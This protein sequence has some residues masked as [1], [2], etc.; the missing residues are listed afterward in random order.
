VYAIAVWALPFAHAV[1]LDGVPG[2]AAHAESQGTHDHR[3]AH[4]SLDCTIF[5]VARLL[6]APPQRVAIPAAGPVVAAARSSA[7]DGPRL[8]L[9]RGPHRSRAPP[10]A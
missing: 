8:P 1:C 6:A 4:D 10:L 3:E 7:P 2:P 5:N 9:A